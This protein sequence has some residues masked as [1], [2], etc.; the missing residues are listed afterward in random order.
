MVENKFPKNQRLLELLEDYYIRLYGKHKDN[1]GDATT[2][3]A[4]PD[5]KAYTNIRPTTSA[6]ENQAEDAPSEQST[7]IYNGSITQEEHDPQHY[8]EET[9]A[10][11]AVNIE[12]PMPKTDDANIEKEIVETAMT[13][14]GGVVTQILANEEFSGI[15][16][17]RGKILTG[18][19]TDS[20]KPGYPPKLTDLSLEM[21][22]EEEV[23]WNYICHA[24][25]KK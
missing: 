3:T 14:A 4:H 21:V 9:R 20:P 8:P 7:T 24:D 23:F 16:E 22:F 15:L 11:V 10:I 2:S 1:K 13:A 17:E 6:A 5:P 25:I 18:N 19:K 12:S